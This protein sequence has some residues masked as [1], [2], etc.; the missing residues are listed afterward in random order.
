MDL[1]ASMRAMRRR[2]ILTS[3]LFLLT[4]AAAA[5]SW[6]KLPGPYQTESMVVLLPSHQSSTINGNNPYLSFGGSLNVAGDIVL[7]EIMAPKTVVSLAAQG[8]TSSYTVVDDPLTS[9]PILDITVTGSSKS[10][11]ETTLQGVTAATQAQLDSLQSSLKPANRIT[12][13]VVSF[14][15]TAKLLTSKKA[16]TLVIVLGFGLV[17]TYAIPQIVDAEIT[18]RRTRRDRRVT[19]NFAIPSPSPGTPGAARPTAQPT[20]QPE[21]VGRTAP[22][23][24]MASSSGPPAGFDSPDRTDHGST[25]QSE[26]HQPDWLAAGRRGGGQPSSAEEDKDKPADA[27]AESAQRR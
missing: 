3:I 1:A 15:P 25:A 20:A 26:Y 21:P 10:E 9:G 4:L 12:S 19:A 18:R 8:Y 5:M 27:G 22:P 2:W 14:N 24:F 17:L 16:R 13:Q 11:V 6:V 7:R 23:A